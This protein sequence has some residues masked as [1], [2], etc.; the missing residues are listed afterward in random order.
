MSKEELS[1]REMLAEDVDPI[2]RYWTHSEPGDLTSMGVDLGK[3]PPAQE[4]H[5]MISSQLGQS[6]H[7]KNSY[8]IIWL[9]GNKPVG[10]SNINKIVYGQEAYMHLHLWDSTA[11]KKGS[12][13]KFVKLS[14]AYFFR[15]MELKKLYCEPFAFNVAPNRTLAKAG[16]TFVKQY[17]T[18]PGSLNFEQE[19]NLWEMSVEDFLKSRKSLF[20]F[21]FSLM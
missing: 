9:Y 5:A 2:V 18:V 13:L 4:M 1:V 14:L 10:H 7:E 21:F 15:N 3:I 19:V 16:F 6:Y 8:C 17:K 11:R 20:R 12:G